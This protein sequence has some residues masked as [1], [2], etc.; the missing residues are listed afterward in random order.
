MAGRRK[1]T[2]GDVIIHKSLGEMTVRVEVSGRWCCEKDGRL[3]T[4]PVISERELHLLLNRLT[5]QPAPSYAF[6]GDR[7]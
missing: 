7:Q 1:L 5:R 2:D 6:K 3:A 4:S